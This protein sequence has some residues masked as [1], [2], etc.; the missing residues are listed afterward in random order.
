MPTGTGRTELAA[1]SATL[2]VSEWMGFMNSTASS[3]VAILTGASSG[4]GR[5]LAQQLA[6]DGFRMGL[7]ARRAGELQSLAEEI[8]AAGGV[9]EHE[10]ADVVDRPAL[11]A[12]IHRLAEKLGPVDLLVA[13]AGM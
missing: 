8:R 12:A 9:A 3:K 5:A 1:Q 13:N 4:I 6:R 11:V 7:L 2:L 10:V